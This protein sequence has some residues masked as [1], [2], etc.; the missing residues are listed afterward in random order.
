MLSGD[1]AGK[2][3]IDCT[4]NHHLP[5]VLFH[6]LARNRDAAYLELP[7]AGS[8]VPARSGKLTLL[9]SGNRADYE[10]ALPYLEKIGAARFFLGAPGQATRMKLINNLLRCYAFLT[11]LNCD[12]YSVF[13]G[14]ADVND[15]L[16]PESQIP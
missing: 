5:V 15:V 16:A 11:G 7:V 8:V 12:G 14:P 6:E 13:V 9:A 2:L 10:R 1:C 3:I 4:T